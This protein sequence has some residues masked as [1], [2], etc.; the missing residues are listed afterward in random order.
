MLN[1]SERSEGSDTHAEGLEALLR[2]ACLGL[3]VVLHVDRNSN[4]PVG[5]E[6]SAASEA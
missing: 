2:S 6:A 5:Q 1:A 3:Q 4:P